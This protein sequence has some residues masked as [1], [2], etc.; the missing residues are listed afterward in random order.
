MSV[1]VCVLLCFFKIV[2][3]LVL[4]QAVF[5]LFCCYRVCMS[6]FQIYLCLKLAYTFRTFLGL[7]YFL[8]NLHL[9]LPTL[10]DFHISLRQH[11]DAKQKG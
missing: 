9:N 4:S 3:A 1:Y 2:F 8:G 10:P 7:D 11:G 6:A 5:I